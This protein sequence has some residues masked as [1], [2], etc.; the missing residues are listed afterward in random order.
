MERTKK[1][2]PKIGC[3]IFSEYKGT[4]KKLNSSIN[5][6]KIISKKSDKAQELLDIVE[7][8]Q[9]C[10]KYDEK[11]EDCI[12]CHYILNLRKEIAQLIIDSSETAS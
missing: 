3:P 6:S 4:I 8:L 1:F 10:P 2:I 9:S 7:I 11:R 5:G 12:N